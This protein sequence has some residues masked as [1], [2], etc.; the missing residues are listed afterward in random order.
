MKHLSENRKGSGN[1]MFYMAPNLIVE[2]DGV[3]FNTG[4]TMERLAGPE[5]KSKGILIVKSDNNMSVTFTEEDSDIIDV[6]V[7]DGVH[8][9]TKHFV[10]KDVTLKHGGMSIVFS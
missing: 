3:S 9:Q 6:I 8:H 2:I 10:K 1:E 4:L 7:I 5:F